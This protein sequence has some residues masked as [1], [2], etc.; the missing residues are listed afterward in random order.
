MKINP[1]NKKMFQPS[2]PRLIGAELP[3]I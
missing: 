2:Q 3:D 1:V